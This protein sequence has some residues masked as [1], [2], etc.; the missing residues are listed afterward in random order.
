M[1]RNKPPLMFD[2]KV[3]L[4]HEMKEKETINLDTNTEMETLIDRNNSEMNAKSGPKSPHVLAENN[5][6]SD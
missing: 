2:K 5:S 4:I 3:S 1:A 6:D